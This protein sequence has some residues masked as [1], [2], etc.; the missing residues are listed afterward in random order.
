MAQLESRLD[1][2]ITTP[3]R[4]VRSKWTNGFSHF[5]VGAPSDYGTS[6]Y[7]EYSARDSVPIAHGAQILHCTL[8]I[9]VV[10][11]TA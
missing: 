6:R 11:S 8:V 3:R 10:Q 4:N 2:Q 9:S 5:A 7:V 1:L